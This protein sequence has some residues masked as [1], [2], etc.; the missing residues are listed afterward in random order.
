M[1]RNNSIPINQDSLRHIW[2]YILKEPIA[3]LAFVVTYFMGCGVAFVLFYYRRERV[4]GWRGLDHFFGGGYAAVIFTIMNWK[5]VWN[6]ASP[7]TIDQIKN[8]TPQTLLLSFALLFI[9]TTVVTIVRE[10]KRGG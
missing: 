10:R 5:E 9:I 1:P 8:R 7:I 6:S 3:L 2:P 4:H